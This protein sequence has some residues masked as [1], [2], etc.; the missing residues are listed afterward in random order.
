MNLEYNTVF[1][2]LYAYFFF[3]LSVVSYLKEKRVKEK[4]LQTS[5]TGVH[6]ECMLMTLLAFS[7]GEHNQVVAL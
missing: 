3:S 2:K 1:Y 5:A 4:K 6:Q 7:V